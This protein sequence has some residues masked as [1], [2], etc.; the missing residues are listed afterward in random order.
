[1]VVARSAHG[2]AAA[3][4][5]R[6]GCAAVLSLLACSG[7]DGSPS[8]TPDVVTED[9]GC[10]N[11]AAPLFG[12]WSVQWGDLHAHTVFSDDAATQNPPPGDPAAALAWAVDPAGGNLDF[13]AITDHAETIASEEWAS[14]LA[15]ESAWPAGLVVFPAFEYTN[16]G[17]DA[18]HGHK[19]VLVEGPEFVPALPL[20]VDGYADPVALWAALDA[21]PTAGHY[22]T[23]PHH[24][25][26][27]IDYGANMS[28]DWSD[29]FVDATRQP[30]VEI[31]SVHGSSE[32]DGCEEPV[33]RFRSACSVEAALHR[34]LDT[35]NAGYKLG[36]LGSTDNHKATPGAVAEI[37]ANVAAKEGPYT[38]GLAG[39]WAASRERGAIWSALREKRTFATSGARIALE[40]TARAGATI[41]PMGA[42]IEV[43]AGTK[44]LLHVRAI[45]E[46]GEAIER[47][48][49]IRNGE[50]I[51]DAR[52]TDHVDYADPSVTRNAYYRV[53][54]YQSPTAV[55]DPTHCANE[56]AW[57][58]P[59]WV[60]VR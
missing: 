16:C 18:G 8:T 57:S 30:L 43:V 1:M 29:P 58:S 24:S 32:S 23:V 55:V 37:D 20:G 28:T 5:I 12:G 3:V 46:S 26:K 15:T 54:V 53:K 14:T 13:V 27:G 9:Y 52:G 21:S 4:A 7:D 40:F 44:V 49:L 33:D 6:I 25:A 42:T 11:G 39:V 45:A 41:A 59:I 38:G 22:M 50:T 17:R 31:Y 10:V 60:E 36:I 56:R 47:I 48:V 35:G 34:W 2:R 19:C 51:A